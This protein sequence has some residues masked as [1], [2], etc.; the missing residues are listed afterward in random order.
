MSVQTDRHEEAMRLW[1]MLQQMTRSERKERLENDE[2]EVYSTPC[3]AMLATLVFK[4]LGVHS[5]DREVFWTKLFGRSV[6]DVWK[7]YAFTKERPPEEFANLISRFAK[8]TPP[9][10]EEVA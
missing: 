3:S 2:S 4:R 5:E 7:F 6:G 8:N 10:I 1:R 9:L